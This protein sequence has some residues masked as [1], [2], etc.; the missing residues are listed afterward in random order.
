[1]K[2]QEGKRILLDE[3]LSIGTSQ[4]KLAKK[5]GLSVSTVKRWLMAAKKEAGDDYVPLEKQAVVSARGI[6]E[7]I[8]KVEDIE[9][10]KEELYNARLKISLL[11]AMI[12]ISDE[13]FGTNIRKK[14]GTRQS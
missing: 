14:P 4:G 11:E 1:M 9:K 6:P 12:D 7:D 8:R 2:K 13:Q 5:Y 3:Y 10:L